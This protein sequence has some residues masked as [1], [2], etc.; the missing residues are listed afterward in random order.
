MLGLKTV[1]TKALEIAFLEEGPANGWPV[2][3]APSL[4]LRCPCL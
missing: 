2:V 4:P 1:Q 3:L